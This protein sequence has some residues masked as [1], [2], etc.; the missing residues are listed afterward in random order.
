MKKKILIVEDYLNI[1]QI[2]TMRL[3]ALGYDVICAYDGQE[4]LK[5]AREQKP[6]LIILDILLPKMNGY[7]VC[8]LLK[9]DAK[10]KNIPI[11]MLTSRETK[12]HEQLGMETGADEYVY[13]SDQNGRLLKL[14][15]KYLKPTAMAQR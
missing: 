14:V 9:F 7:K 6:D 8:R 10:Y 13:K 2:L 3:Q 4:G 15:Q 12:R 5:L 11:I 1:V